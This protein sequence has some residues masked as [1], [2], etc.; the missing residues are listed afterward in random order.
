M[1]VGAGVVKAGRAYVEIFADNS[2]FN[3]KLR[4]TEATFRNFGSQMTQASAQMLSSITA[5]AAPLALSSKFYAEFDDTMRSVYSTAGKIAKVD[6]YGHGLGSDLKNMLHIGRE[7]EAQARAI[8]QEFINL[9]KTSRT[10]RNDVIYC[11]RSRERNARSCSR[12][13]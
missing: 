9:T 6:M 13:V 3:Q 2:R 4:E 7:T 12:R 1:A 8:N 11:K 10:R 5:I